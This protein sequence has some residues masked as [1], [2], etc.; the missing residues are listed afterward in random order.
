MSAAHGPA[1]GPPPRSRWYVLGPALVAVLALLLTIATIMTTTGTEDGAGGSAGAPGSPS[2]SAARTPE[3][4][5]PSRPATSD[6]RRPADP[7]GDLAGLARRVPG[8]PLAR[9]SV[10]APVVLLNYSDFQCPFCARFARDTEPALEKYVAD[11]TLR[12]EW[13]DFPYLGGESWVAA[14]AGRAAARQGG[15]WEF[16]D[17]LYAAQPRP[18]SGALT[19]ARLARIAESAGL[20][21]ARLRADMKDPALPREIQDDFDEGLSFG[22]SGTPAFLINGELVFGAQPT[23]VFV[24]AIE[25]AAARAD[26]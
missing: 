8:D 20:D 5:T 13:R 15:F 21:A 19:A 25:R 14:L 7:A 10:D 4:T 3:E 2:A 26:G 9:G 6:A 23:A 1:P 18:N 11:G 16:H 12:I 22:V 17:A 24:R